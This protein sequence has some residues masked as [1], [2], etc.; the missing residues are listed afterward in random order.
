[1]RGDGRIIG[2]E[3]YQEKVHYREEWEEAPENGKELL[4]SAHG[5]GMNATY[6]ANMPVWE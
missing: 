6:V 3:G 2:G 5:N 1:V 4:H